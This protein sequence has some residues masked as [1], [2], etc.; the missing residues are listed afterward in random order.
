MSCIDDEPG[1]LV[2]YFVFSFIE[3]FMIIF[4]V[5]LAR[6]GLYQN[7]FKN[8]KRMSKMLFF[9]FIFYS[10]YLFC[11]IAFLVE[12]EGEATVCPIIGLIIAGAI[13]VILLVKNQVLTKK[14]KRLEEIL[15]QKLLRAQTS[16][17]NGGCSL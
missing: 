1:P 16:G 12:Y 14:S 2:A 15:N 11:Y 17:L 6:S 3:H 9:A 8:M 13:Y 5:F 4:T 10:L 7:N